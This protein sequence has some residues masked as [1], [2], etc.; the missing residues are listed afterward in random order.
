E[1]DASGARSEFPVRRGVSGDLD[2]ARSGAGMEA[3]I[4]VFQFDPAG[5]C[6][7]F[8]IALAGLFGIDVAGTGVDDEAALETGGVDAAG[9]G[10]KFCI[11]SYTVVINVAGA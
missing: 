4:H 3:S 7:R 5:T 2:V 9:A 10:S 6:L 11:L 8:Y 1:F